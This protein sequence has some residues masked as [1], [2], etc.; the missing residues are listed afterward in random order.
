MYMYLNEYFGI[1]YL[2]KCKISPEKDCKMLDVFL[3]TW[4]Q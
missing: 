3:N 2:A 4:P 1:A